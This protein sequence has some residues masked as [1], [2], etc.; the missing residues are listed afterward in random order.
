MPPRGR[1]PKP[2]ALKLVQGNPGNRP[3]PEDEPEIEAP[4]E[5]PDPPDHLDAEACREW[6]RTG[7]I[8]LA[9]GLLTELDYSALALLCVAHSRHKEATDQMQ[10]FGM[11]QIAP[12]TGYPM[13]SPYLAISNKA[14]DQMMKI[15]AE[16]GMSPSSRTRVTPA[17]STK[18]S[19]L[20][21]Y[22][23]VK[24]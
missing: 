19:K 6:N 22:R 8:L 14:M 9:A 1:K 23:T 12:G 15:H 24:R 20:A 18:V 17:K 5:L 2:T 11:L 4:S 13:Q 21:K 7:A 3:L 16:F 10:K